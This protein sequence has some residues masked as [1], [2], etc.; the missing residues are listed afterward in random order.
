MKT[1]T[2]PKATL[3]LVDDIPANVS[4]LFD[5]LIEEGF[6]VLVSRDGKQAIQTANTILPNLILLD[7]M[8]PGID[9]FEVCQQLKS[10]EE[11]QDIPIIFMTALTDVVDKVRGFRLGA[12]DYITKPIQQEEVLAR[13]M[14][15]LRLCNLQKELQESVFELQVQKSELEKRNQE[16]DAFSRTVAHDLK[17]PLTGIIGLTD[18]VASSCSAIDGINPKVLERVHV[19]QQAGQK[20]LTIIEELLLLA[21]VSKQR[22]IPLEPLDMKNIVE[23]IIYNRLSYMIENVQAKILFPETWPVAVGYAPWI[24]EVWA[25]YISNGI[26]YGGKPPILQFGAQVEESGVRFWLKDNGMGISSESQKR[27]FTPFTRLHEEHAEG[28][29]L[30]LSIVQQIVEKLNGKVGVESELDTGSL[31]YFILPTS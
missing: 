23:Q 24:E 30:G 2:P 3:L 17:N 28:H 18:S 27:L 21:G 29:G 5:F 14:T 19:V 16:L 12:A 8:M 1:N 20:M 22:D 10:Q 6:R 9:G 11:T 13:I 15:H 7:V 25:N 4:V 26:K 31:F